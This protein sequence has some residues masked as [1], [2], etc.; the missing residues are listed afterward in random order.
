LNSI[1]FSE[2]VAEMTCQKSTF[3][4]G[5]SIL[6]NVSEFD[7]NSPKMIL[8]AGDA[9]DRK[10]FRS[11]AGNLSVICMQFPS[12]EGGYG[13]DP[14]SWL[15]MHAALMRWKI[16]LPHVLHIEESSACIWTTD[17]GD[18]FLNRNLGS[19]PLDAER[20]E[21]QQI[22]QFYRD[23]LML[24]VQAQYPKDAPEIEHPALQRF[25][26]AKKLNFELN[27]FAEHFLAGLLG[28]T[29]SEQLKEEFNELSEQ[30]ASMEQVLCHRDY[31][32]RNLMICQDQVHWIDFQDA[33]MGPHCYDVVSLLRDS[34]VRFEHN[35][36]EQLF[37]EYF[38]AMNNARRE[39]GRAV[40]SPAD[41]FRERLL[42]GLQRNIKAL[43]SFGY[44]CRVKNKKVYLSFVSHTVETIL[45]DSAASEISLQFP[46]TFA[47]LKSLAAGPLKESYEAVL[48]RESIDQF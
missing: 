13:G 31:H 40:I 42:V 18:H 11:R 46:R 12:W 16:P 15:G 20:Q 22:Y 44:L 1:A 24:L 47:M 39:R 19:V 5:E 30:I 43:G 28:Q 4:P 29:V 36:R 3:I 10:F 21:H 17:L 33:R 37:V 27:F 2:A 38:D 7:P 32:A 9:S 14:L 34:Y 6:P 48:K 25:F 41:F 45:G 23:S 8:I 35:T 26:D